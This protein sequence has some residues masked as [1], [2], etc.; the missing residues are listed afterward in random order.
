MRWVVGLALTLAACSGSEDPRESTTTARD[1]SA[2]RD[3]TRV[4][5]ESGDQVEIRQGPAFA[6]QVEGKAAARDRLTLRRDGDTLRIARK[7]RELWSDGND[8]ARV[9][10]TMPALNAATLAGSGDITID[11]ASD[12]F[13]GTL[14]GSGDMTIGQLRGEKAALTVAGT[15]KIAAAGAVRRITL[16]VAGSGD[17]DARQVRANEAVVSVAGSGDIRAAVNGPAQVSL[18]GSGSA[19]LGPD[20]RCV[21][22]QVGS[23]TSDCG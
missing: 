16:S 4:V 10:I 21:V 19:T 11:R 8:V 7:G 20:A 14:S 9:R 13:V 22:T 5:L 23:G 1:D 2:L 18:V 12:D 3:F 17:I 15:G 6:V